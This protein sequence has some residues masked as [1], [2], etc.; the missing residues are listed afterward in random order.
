M[1]MFKTKRMVSRRF[2]PTGGSSGGGVFVANTA[3]FDGTDY[4]RLSAV[5]TGIADGK[6]F[7]LSFWADS[8]NSLTE[9]TYLSAASAGTNR[10]LVYRPNGASVIRVIGRNSAGTTILDITSSLTLTAAAGWQHVYIA[11]D[12]STAGGTELY[13]IYVNNVSDGS[14]IKSVFTNDTIDFNMATPSYTVGANPAGA[15]LFNGEMC[16]FWL[17]DVYLNDTSKFYSAGKPIS[18]GSNG[19]TP[20]GSVPVMYFS[21]NGSGNS[22]ATDSSSNGNTMTVTG[23]LGTGT[24]P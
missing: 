6:A 10:F 19:Q 22:W 18:L 15:N 8:A 2:G 23:S 4:M 5:P 17:D 21:L 1:S 11:V 14:I 20:T 9:A 7:T 13:K 12:L 3:V 24:P 16:E